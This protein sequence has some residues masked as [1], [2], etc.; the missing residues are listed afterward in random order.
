MIEMLLRSLSRVC[1]TGSVNEETQKDMGEKDQLQAMIKHEEIQ[2]VSII[3][4]YSILEVTVSGIV[5]TMAG[6]L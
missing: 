1:F 2:T 5:F 3:P 4:M 6:W